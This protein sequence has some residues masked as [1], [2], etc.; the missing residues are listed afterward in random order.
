MDTL[1]SIKAAAVKLGGVSV[2]A[3]KAWISQ[4]KLEKTKIGHRTMISESEL[5]RF[6]D[7]GRIVPIREASVV[8]NKAMAEE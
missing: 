2:S 1:Y 6:R 4:G 8:E 7:A 3:I 5:Q